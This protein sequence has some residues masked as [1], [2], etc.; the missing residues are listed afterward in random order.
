MQDIILNMPP[1]AIALM[2]PL[3]ALPGNALDFEKIG[4]VA[5][6]NVVLFVR[7]M[8]FVMELVILGK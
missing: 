4:T 8:V 1:S 2:W 7:L 5:N 6:V 3:R